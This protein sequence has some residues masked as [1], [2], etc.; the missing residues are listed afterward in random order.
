[1]ILY[2][3]NRMTKHGM[4]PSS[5]E[6]LGGML[7]QIYPMK[8]ISDKKN[9][10]IRAFDIIFELVR[11]AS[12]IR[13]VLL[14]MYSTSGFYYSL[15]VAFLCK[16]FFIP[17]IPI[18]HGGNLPQRYYAS[19]T[20]VSFI[21]RSAKVVVAP[22]EYLYRFFSE[23]H[24]KRLLLI[25]NSLDTSLYIFKPRLLIK[26]KFLWVRS[27]HSIYN[28]Q[29]AVRVFAQV[30]EKFPAASMAMVGA[31]QDGSLAECKLLAL[32]KNVADSI[33]FTGRLPKM[34][35]IKLSV[36]YDI[37]LNT[38]NFDNMPVSVLEGMALGLPIVSTNVGGLPYLLKDDEDALLVEANDEQRM[39]EKIETLLLQEGLGL[40]LSRAARSKVEGFDWK[41]IKHQ[42]HSIL[43]Q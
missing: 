37:F 11:N 1:M 8:L 9:P 43:S 32:E 30:K 5:V 26:P 16:I 34:E 39:V 20:L 36:D 12:R 2:I 3:G 25:P 41:I 29:L 19:K 17:Y 23:Q 14:D 21:L 13:F 6:T 7:K 40:R 42:W 24:F 18:L 28:P 35:W 33:T 15:M 31:E 38:T 4:N 22:S 27:F 10:W